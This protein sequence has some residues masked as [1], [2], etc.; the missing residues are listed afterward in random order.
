VG[1]R[2][3]PFARGV[4]TVYEFS[5]A[6]LEFSVLADPA[7]EILDTEIKKVKASWVSASLLLTTEELARCIPTVYVSKGF[8]SR[9]SAA[10]Q[11]KKHFG[12]IGQ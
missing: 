8:Q 9:A 10:S 2:D 3:R 5:H 7:P 4:A 1:A 6:G 12:R 11:L